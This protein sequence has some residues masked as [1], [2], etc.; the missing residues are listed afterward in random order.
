MSVK[1]T[2]PIKNWQQAF[3]A[4]INDSAG[5]DPA[6]LAQFQGGIRKATLEIDYK[7]SDRGGSASANLLI[8]FYNSEAS[9][10]TD[11]ITV[12]LEEGKHNIKLDIKGRSGGLKLVNVTTATIDWL[13]FTILDRETGGN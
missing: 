8:Q 11:G 10:F 3:V 9:E 13:Y 1:I 4:K 12:P 5:G 6:D 7:M 2:D